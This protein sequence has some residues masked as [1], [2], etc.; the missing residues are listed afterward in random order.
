MIKTAVGAACLSH[1]RA[2]DLLRQLALIAIVDYPAMNIDNKRFAMRQLVQIN[3]LILNYPNVCINC[4]KPDR[5]Q[6]GFIYD[7]A[8]DRK[9]ASGTIKI[10]RIGFRTE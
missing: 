9:G 2:I 5:L 8:D 7:F 1:D 10:A 3:H 6:R 4:D